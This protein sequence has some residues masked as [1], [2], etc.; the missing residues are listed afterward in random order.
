ML[1]TSV[2]HETKAEADRS[3]GGGG[4]AHDDRPGIGKPR[5][6]GGE[7]RAL[8]NASMEGSVIESIK[9]PSIDDL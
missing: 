1:S 4:K 8:Y 9:E 6:D 7:D 5:A 3:D 2:S